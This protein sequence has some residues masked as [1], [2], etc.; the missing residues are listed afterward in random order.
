M[1]KELAK[2]IYLYGVFL[3]PRDELIEL[4]GDD[5]IAVSYGGKL[6]VLTIEEAPK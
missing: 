5:K 2:R 6:Y 3:E 4:L 1:D